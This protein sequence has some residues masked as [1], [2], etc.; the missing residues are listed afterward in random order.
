[1]DTLWN[2]KPGFCFGCTR[3][4][5]VTVQIPLPLGLTVS[6]FVITDHHGLDANE[7]MKTQTKNLWVTEFDSQEQFQGAEE[8]PSL[9]SYPEECLIPGHE[10]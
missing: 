4:S 2:Q 9:I 5:G 1:M 3:P 6:S 7:P 8:L 10:N